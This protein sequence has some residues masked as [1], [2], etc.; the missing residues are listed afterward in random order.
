VI[1]AIPD[2]R[3]YVAV[4]SVGAARLLIE[5]HAHLED[6]EGA[7]ASGQ[8]L[9]AAMQARVTVLQSL[10]L[11]SLA[12]GGESDSQDD[13]VSF[14]PFA[15]VSASD[16]AEAL[17]LIRAGIDPS[18]D[19]DAWAASVRNHLVAS[20]T[21][22]G[23]GADMPSLRTPDGLFPALRYA[24]EWA[25]IHQDLDLPPLLPGEWLG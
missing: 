25:R 17:H 19:V 14:D 18:A 2:I 16:R 6:V 8:R 21:A 1:R 23:L 10:A 20:Q 3:R 13:S 4:R 22:A 9:V 12:A 11:R 24:R 7:T 15:G 5:T